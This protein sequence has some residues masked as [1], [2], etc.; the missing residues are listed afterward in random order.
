[1]YKELGP[2]SPTI[3]KNVLGLVLQII[4]YS[5]AFE[6]NTASDWLNHAV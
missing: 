1:M 3:L 2:Y 6:C 5:E 4:L